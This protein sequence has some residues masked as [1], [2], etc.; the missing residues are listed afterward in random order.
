MPADDPRVLL[1]S[2]RNIEQQLWR[3]CQHEFEEVITGL[4]SVRLL[5]PPRRRQA[6]W[7]QASLPL[8]RASAQK[9][10]LPAPHVLPSERVVI[11]G[12]Y[13]L[14][15]GVFN[16]AWELTHLRH[17]K[18]WRERCRKALCFI[19][20][21]WT[22]PE[23]TRQFELLRDFDHV[24]AAS[25]RCLPRIE[26][27]TR[28]PCEYLPL[29]VDAAL[30]CPYPARPPRVIDV[31]SFGRRSPGTHR[32]L[33]DLA[34]QDAITYVFDSLNGGSIPSVDH[35]AHRASLTHLMKRSRY[36]MAYRF[37]ESPDALARTAGEEHIPLRY[38]EATAGGAVLLGSSPRTPDWDAC[39]DW[40]D[41]VIPIAWDAHDIGRVLA[42][43][44]AQPDRLA[45]ARRHNVA[46][47]LRRHDWVYRWGRVLDAAGLPHPAQMTDRIAHLERLAGL[48]E[49]DTRQG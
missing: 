14:F 26:E 27:I 11:D 33:L 41:A 32:A 38:F 19:L 48:A 35:A 9:L 1:F 44:D 46:N 42:D 18:G 15:F 43:L 10:G 24:F 4:D 6:G 34:A 20:E 37:N 3:S 16:F 39:F 30:F 49:A 2:Q 23:Y 25:R 31:Y 13:D 12:E 5:A 7:V 40:P 47:A 36:V 21:Q 29:G 22:T 28:R 8:V 45:R 17:M